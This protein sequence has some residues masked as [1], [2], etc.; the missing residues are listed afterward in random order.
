MAGLRKRRPGLVYPVY[1]DWHY[2]G[3]SGEPAFE[4]SFTNLSGTTMMAFRLRESGVVDI[5]GVIQGGSTGNS[6]FELPESHRPSKAA[7]YTAST[8]GPLGTAAITINTGGGV[9]VVFSGTPTAL[10]VSG[11]FFLDPPNLAA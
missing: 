9:V 8:T 10:L 4:H 1:D 3:E 6:I 2:V 7:R 5:Q 11:Q